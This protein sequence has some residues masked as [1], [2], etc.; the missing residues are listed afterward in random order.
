MPVTI[1]KRILTGSTHGVGQS[2]TATQ[3]ATYNTVHQLST[4]ATTTLDEVYVYAQNNFSQSVEITFE[5]GS[6]QSGIHIVAQAPAREGPTLVI[7]GMIL[8]G[9]ACSIAAFVQGIGGSA[10]PAVSGSSLISVYG[11]VNRIVQT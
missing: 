2:I 6:S 11:Y 4:S 10:S 8:T 1:T 7:P 9:S 3:G 5:F